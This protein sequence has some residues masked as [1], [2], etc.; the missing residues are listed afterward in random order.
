VTWDRDYFQP[1]DYAERRCVATKVLM[2]VMGAMFGLWVAWRLLIFRTSPHA[3]ALEEYVAFIPWDFVHRLRLWQILSHVFLVLHPL[4]LVFNLIFLYFFGRMIEE[5]V[6]TRKFLVLFFGG[7]LFAALVFLAIGY[8][9]LPSGVYTGPE[10]AIMAVLVMAAFTAP[11]MQVLFYFMPVK[12]KYL[13]LVYIGLNIFNVLSQGHPAYLAN[14]A[15]AVWGFGFWKF[16]NRISKTLERWDEESEH[17][18]EKKARRRAEN[19]EAEL[20]RI[21]A[22]IARD[23]MTSLTS[24]ERNT[25]EEASRRKRRE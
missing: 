18:E 15:G 24:S 22:K 19:M 9:L 8:F 4:T 16:H 6:G 7:S 11:N 21:L 14:L 13:A 17:R 12:L 25:L 23:G 5:L 20:D 2:I 10:G 3:G 1:S